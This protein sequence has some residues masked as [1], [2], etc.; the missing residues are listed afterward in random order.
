VS[1]DS[2][3]ASAPPSRRS[4]APLIL[5]SRSPR[6]AELLR[7]A[8]VD[9][10]QRP[11]PF[12]DPLT[13]PVGSAARELALQLAERKARAL[14]ATLQKAAA[15]L[16]ADTVVLSPDGTLVGTPVHAAEARRMIEAFQG[17]THQVVSAAVLVQS[18]DLAR[19]GRPPRPGGDDEHGGEDE[20]RD[21][22]A[23]R[24]LNPT[25]R[26]LA[27]VVEKA[28]VL[29]GRLPCEAVRRHL[30]SGAWRGKAGGYNFAEVI[31]RWPVQSDDDPATIM[32]LPLHSLLPHLESW[33]CPDRT[34]SPIASRPGE[35]VADGSS[36]EAT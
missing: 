2:S 7:E 18:G 9:F 35:A 33:R 6:R 31:D 15:V 12:E 20:A 22:G 8:G 19:G 10:E 11:S 29:M 28:D 1:A 34:S 3:S 21:P 32:G 13:P 27:R 5:A 26:L 16:G 30:D 24:G 23:A 25:H 36:P 4:S 17:S 14:A